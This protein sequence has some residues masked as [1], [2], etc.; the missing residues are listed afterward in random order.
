MLSIVT[1]GLV[2]LT[3]LTLLILK[4]WRINLGILGIQYIGVFLLVGKEWPITLAITQ[5]IVG[6]IAISIMVMAILS[7]SSTINYHPLHYD[8]GQTFSPIFYFLAAIFVD[9]A[10]ASAAP[11]F[12]QLI[13][14][15]ELF[16]AWSGLVL[17]GLGLLRLGFTSYPLSAICSLITLLSGFEVLYAP[18][19]NSVFTA[20]LLAVIILGLAL[21]GSYLFV[22]PHLEEQE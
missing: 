20:G 12:S 15:T 3:S 19:D 17:I 11:T 7:V 14:G 2:A 21:A 6:W 10:A 8:P 16:Q 1:P 13:P 18:M 4:D 9:L 5:L 22:A